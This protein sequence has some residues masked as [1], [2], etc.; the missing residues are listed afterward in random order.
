MLT[1]K[2]KTFLIAAE[3]SVVL[4]AISAITLCLIKLTK[5]ILDNHEP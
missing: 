1:N 2:Q 4:V 5:M 3:G